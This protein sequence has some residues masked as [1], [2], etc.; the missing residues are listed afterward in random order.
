M[1]MD[2]ALARCEAPFLFLGFQ[3]Q[4]SRLGV[5]GLPHV[6]KELVRFLVIGRTL[7]SCKPSAVMAI[8]SSAAIRPC[9][10]SLDMKPQALSSKGPPLSNQ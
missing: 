7:A 2:V 3:G 1:V 4:R 5:D 10:S 8:T 6:E 9:S